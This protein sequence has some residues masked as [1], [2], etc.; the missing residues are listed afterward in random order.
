[1]EIVQNQSLKPYPLQAIRGG[2]SLNDLLHSDEK[3]LLNQLSEAFTIINGGQF[4]KRKQ[5]A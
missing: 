4:K 5:I 2:K 1:M 3:E